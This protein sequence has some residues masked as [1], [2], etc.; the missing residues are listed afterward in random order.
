V[1]VIRSSGFRWHGVEER[2]YKS[3]DGSHS[4]VTRHRLLGGQP[5]E[6]ALRFETRYFEVAAGG[7]TSLERHQHPHAV[8]VI[9]GS[10]SLADAGECVGIRP[11][12]CVYVAPDDVHQFRA[13]RGEPLGFLC[14][15]DR[16]RDRPIL[17]SK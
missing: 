10:G 11:F 1:K 13:D 7:H 8:V 12:D 4:G 3:E 2:G 9:R 15:V 5:D 14:V 16:D 17:V 6:A